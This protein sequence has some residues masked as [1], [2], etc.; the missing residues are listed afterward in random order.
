MTCSRVRRA[1]AIVWSAAAFILFASASAAAQTVVVRKVP[2]GSNVEV[3]GNTGEP[4]TAKADQNG[5]AVVPLGTPV[6]KPGV[7]TRVLVFVDRCG[8]TT[9]VIIVDAD[10]QP[11]PA[12]ACARRQI[13][14]LFIARPGTTIMVNV[15]GTSPSVLLRQGSWTLAA[16]RSVRRLPTGL[17]LFGGA[18]YSKI[19]DASLRACGQELCIPDDSGFAFGGGVDIWITPFLGAELSYNRNADAKSQGQGTRFLFN[20]TFESD[21]LVLAGKLALPAGPVRFYG[22]AGGSYTR[23]SMETTQTTDPLTITEEGVERTLEGGE[24]TFRIKSA[25]WGFVWGGGM[26]IWVAPAA[27]LYAEGGFANLRGSG[28]ET[29]DDINLKDRSTYFLFGLKFTIRR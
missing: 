11:N 14:G 21:V 19:R 26:E 15:E 4:V 13:E 12:G 22:K 8:E 1:A 10:L 3:V 24:Q 7:D 23:A 20:T 16:P 25:G 2:A 6:A 9:R 29:V 27:A 28:V 5:D 18:G 17:V